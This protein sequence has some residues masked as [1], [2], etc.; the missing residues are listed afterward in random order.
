M[1]KGILIS[2]GVCIVV[3]GAFVGYALIFESASGAWNYKVTVTIETPEGDVS[4]YAVREISNS[5]SNIGPKLPGSGNP[6]EYKGEA[7]VV[8][9]GE[10]GLV[11]VLRDD[12][13]GSR[14]LR[15]FPEGS[16]F[17]VEG[18]KTYKKTLIPG[19]KATLNPEQ[20]PGYQPIVTFKNLNDPTSVVV[21]MKWKRLDRMKDGRQIELTEDRFQEIF[22]EGVHLKSIEYEIT[23]RA[24][25]YKVRQYLPWIESYFGRQFD[26]KKY[27][28]AGSENPE[29]NRF[30]SY[31]FTP[32]ETQ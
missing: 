18:M 25:G 30:S 17:N 8:D 23:D 20:F 16:L 10:R 31:S 13:E 7:V 11:F 28:T 19:R 9:L 6:A 29:A 24:L 15:L 5:V 1:L 22:G 3:A 26:G 12:R 2:I 32:K 14:F 21:L 4:G 27:Q